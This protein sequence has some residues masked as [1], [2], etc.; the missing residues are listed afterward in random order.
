MSNS[1]WSAL[2]LVLVIEGLLP[3]LNPAAWRRVFEQALSLSDG[4]LR[5]MGLGCILVGLVFFWV[6]P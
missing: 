3:L 4:Q 6:L 2:A 5:F 1:L